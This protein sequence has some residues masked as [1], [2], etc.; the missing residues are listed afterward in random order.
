MH[1]SIPFLFFN[2]QYEKKINQK[3]SN[4][5]SKVNNCSTSSTAVQQL[6]IIFEQGIDLP[7]NFM[8][9]FAQW[10]TKGLSTLTDEANALMVKASLYVFP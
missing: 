5:L 8:I 10:T 3:T 2:L 6:A 4:Y 7:T 1:F 9:Y